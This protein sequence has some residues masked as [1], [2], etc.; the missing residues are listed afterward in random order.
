MSRTS[1]ILYFGKF[2]TAIAPIFAPLGFGNWETGG[3]LVSGFMAKEIIVSSMN[4]I[5]VGEE[6]AATAEPTTLS[7]GYCLHY[8]RICGCD[9]QLGQNSAEHPA[10]CGPG[11]GPAAGRKL[12]AELGPAAAFYNPE[13][14]ITAG[15]SCCL[16]VPCVATLGAI[17]HE[18]GTSWAVT[19]AIYQTA[20]AWMVAFMIYQGG[21]ML[22]FG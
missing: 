18:F 7:G 6:N 16:Y 15:L 17:K 10:R 5:Y 4:Q 13:R 2:S 1:R 11:G 21:L 14:S 8:Q 19:S 9:H 22:G 12:P 20:V 3:A